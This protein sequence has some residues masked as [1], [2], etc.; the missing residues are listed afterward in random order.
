VVDECADRLR[1]PGWTCAD[2]STAGGW[3]VCGTNGENVLRVTAPTHAL[4]WQR[5]VE[6]ARAVGMPR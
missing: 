6:A 4:A 3:R 2:F 5:A 1:L